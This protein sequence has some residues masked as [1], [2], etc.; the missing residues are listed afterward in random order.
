MSGNPTLTERLDRALAGPVFARLRIAVEGRPVLS[1]WLL[2]GPGVFIAA[3]L[4]M[5][6]MPV[7]L[8]AGAAG[9]NNII[10]P[11]VLAPVI[12]A[13]AFTYMCLE[14]NLVRG[15]ALVAGISLFSTLVILA[16][17]AI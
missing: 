9:I 11:L 13:A 7:W 4:F 1:R 12:W 16:S 14:E 6:S 3:V 5:M 17:L 15:A 2:A 8:P 10:W